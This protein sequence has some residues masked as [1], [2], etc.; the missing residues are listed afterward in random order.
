MSKSATAD[1]DPALPGNLDAPRRAACPFSQ[2]IERDIGSSPPATTM[3]AAY[4]T[5][6]FIRSRAFVSLTQQ[7]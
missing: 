4:G 5:I 3:D 6:D 1:F 2:P 7:K